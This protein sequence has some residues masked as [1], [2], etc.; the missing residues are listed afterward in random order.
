MQLPESNRLS[1]DIL[2]LWIMHQF[3]EAFREHAILKGGMQL[4]LLSSDR[5]TNDLD[6]VFSPYTSKKDIEP[7]ID[8]ILSKIPDAKIQKSFHSNSGRYLIQAGLAAVQIEYNVAELMPS[9]TLT[10]QLLAQRVGTLPRIIRVMSNDVAFAHKLA[11]WNERRLMRDL[12]DCYYWYANVK[13]TPNLEVLRNRLQNINSRLPLLKKVKTMPV[14]DFLQQLDR[15]VNQATEEAFLEQLSPLIVMAKLEGFF[16]VF[17][18]Q[19]RQFVGE[20]KRALPLS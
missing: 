6:Y 17:Q 10:T 18:T 14:D 12:Y 15:A 9:T 19:L 7:C 1:N 16:P 4:M 11:A 5:A 13:A 20:L 3:A 8:D 2:M